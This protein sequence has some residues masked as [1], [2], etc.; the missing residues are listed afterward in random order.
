MDENDGLVVAINPNRIYTVSE[1][2]FIWDRWKSVKKN[3]ALPLALNRAKTKVLLNQP[4]EPPPA[5]WTYYIIQNA[6]RAF[7]KD[8]HD[9]FICIEEKKQ[10]EEYY[11]VAMDMIFRHNNQQKKW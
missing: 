2:G 6:S 9:D 4:I 1:C 3:N 11:W 8:Y 5:L 10:S 7:K